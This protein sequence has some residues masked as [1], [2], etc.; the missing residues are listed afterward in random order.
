M[1]DKPSSRLVRRPATGP[2]QSRSNIFRIK[3]QPGRGSV[4]GA[5]EVGAKWRS[6]TA[7]WRT[8][9]AWK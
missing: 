7:D 6:S 4:R 8:S 3:P 9:R 5:G 2:A 1:N